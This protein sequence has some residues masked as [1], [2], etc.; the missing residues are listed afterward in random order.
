[1]PLTQLHRDHRQ[2]LNAHQASTGPDNTDDA[3][4]A[5][6]LA[7]WAHS[8]DR[9]ELA[10]HHAHRART[11][12]PHSEFARLFHLHLQEGHAPVYDSPEAFSAFIRAGGNLQLYRATSRA[13]QQIYQE[14]RPRALL[15][16][17][18]GDGLALL[19]ALRAAPV[20]APHV[21]LVEPSTALLEQAAGALT[22]NGF[23]HRAFAATIEDFTTDR[24]DTGWDLVQ[25]TFAL[26][27]LPPRRR[28]PVLGHLASRT[29]A[30]AV[31]EFD[32]APVEDPFDPDWFRDC[33]GRLEGGLREY[34][35]ER[36]LVGAGFIIPVILGHF[37]TH[38]R[39][40]HEHS[41]QDWVHDLEGAGFTD[42][43]AHHLCDYWWEPAWIIHARGH[44][45]A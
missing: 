44:R 41:V 25:S 13:L 40:N 20:H 18:P 21:D 1:M 35:A 27:S 3:E 31:V 32:V 16:I 28:R 38:T 42:V 36:D 34:G 10:R 45:P 6:Y 39:T 5:L 43:Q 14:Q 11:L 15:D 4:T 37:A 24:P 29:R 8:E 12:D 9:W 26:Q 22:R 19:P 30:L 17:G 2:G 23:A 7:V 33:A